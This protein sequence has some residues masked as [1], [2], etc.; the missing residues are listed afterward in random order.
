MAMTTAR[1]K[2]LAYL[3]KN[4]LASAQEIARALHVTPA[5]AR[6]HLRILAADGRVTVVSAGGEG[7]G[8]PV[9]RY[10]LSAAL[11]GDQLP[12]LLGA[13]LDEWLGG[14][15]PSKREQA[16]RSLAER[17][18]GTPQAE[19]APL[20]RRLAWTVERLN[21][22]HYQARWEAGAEGPRLL[23][24][25]CPYAKVMAAHPELCT[26]DAVLLETLLGRTV[27]PLK[28]T[29]AVLPGMCPFSFEVG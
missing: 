26:M 2:V 1:Q 4:R 6:H 27:T 8:R 11:A 21:Q 14:L 17:M 16:L 22:L 10:G 9:K 23:L 25:P 13:V 7:R 3:K 29:E 18:G 28:R 20:M 24:G 19:S 15:S 5:N 12:A